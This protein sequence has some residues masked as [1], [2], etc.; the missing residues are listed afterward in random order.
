MDSEDLKYDKLGFVEPLNKITDFKTDQK[1]L[2][3]KALDIANGD[4]L[5]ALKYI[6][7]CLAHEGEHV[8][9]VLVVRISEQ[10]KEIAINIYLPIILAYVD[11]EFEN[12]LGYY[13]NWGDGVV[14]HN[15][16]KH[17]YK[18]KNDY[19]IR[20]FGLNIAGFGHQQPTEI[21]KRLIKVISFGNLGHLFKSLSNALYNCENLEY[22]PANIP[23]S[24]EDLSCM[25]SE[26]KK[27]NL[28]IETW[29]VSNVRNMSGMF[30]SC[31][32][33]N[34]PLNGWNVSNVSNMDGMFKLCMK[35]I[36]MLDKW[37]VSNVTNMSQMFSNCERFNQPL[38]TWNT[39]NVNNMV[40]MFNG[41][42]VYNQPLN[43][44]NTRNVTSMAI[45][46]R[47]CTQF[48]QL[49]NSW[50]MSNVEDINSMFFKCINFNQ[51]LDAWTLT[52]IKNI[53]L[54]FEGCEKFNQSLASWKLNKYVMTYCAFTN[55]NI[56]EQ[57]KPYI[58]EEKS[59]WIC[60]EKGW[61]R[62]PEKI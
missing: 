38:N 23:A 33:F 28:S 7:S 25:F 50:D 53:A 6:V 47:E 26:N 22:V 13:V 56:S 1:E 14:T 29:D 51:P 11:A 35:F 37:N 12:K 61:N 30:S 41:C 54:M 43:L 9:M 5:G 20:I 15:E 42:C 8:E 46:F 24:V 57:N 44:W 59:I 49:L 4:P 55:C 58:P 36:Q 60:S 27:F 2:V 17:T 52:K 10:I 32:N 31:I 40:L 34:Q 21:K 39:C 18:E 19:E 3:S 62:N 16:L 45:M 48:N